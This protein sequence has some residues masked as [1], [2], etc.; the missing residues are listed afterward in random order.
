MQ[1]AL[2]PVG[3]FILVGTLAVAL[4]RRQRGTFAAASP[5]VLL[6]A[7]WLFYLEILGL[8]AFALPT[9]ATF[10]LTSEEILKAL[11][12]G[13]LAI[14][15]ILVGYEASRLVPSILPNPSK[16]RSIEDCDAK[17]LVGCQIIGWA[18][19]LYLLHQGK[20]GYLTY[21][22]ATTSGVGRTLLQL[23]AGLVPLSLAVLGAVIWSP[24]TFRSMSRR[25]AR[26]ILIG[27]LPALVL[28]SVASGVKGQLVTLVLPLAVVYILLRGKVPVLAIGC[29]AF[30]LITTFGGLQSYRTQIASGTLSPRGHG[31]AG[32]VYSALSDIVSNW[33][34]A[35]PATHAREFWQNATGEYATLAQTVA[36]IEARTPTSAPY[37]SP[38]RFLDG[39]FFFLPASTFQPPGFNLDTYVNT[40][41]RGGAGNSAAPATQPGDFY[42]SGGLPGVVIGELAVG[43]FVGILWR[44]LKPSPHRYWAVVLYAVIAT[45]FANAGIDF[46]SLMR[47][48]LDDLILYGIITRNAIFRVPLPHARTSDLTRSGLTQPSESTSR[49]LSHTT[50]TTRTGR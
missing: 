38:K 16:R 15:M 13:V 45:E 40:E 5:M 7:F 2:A 39:P 25:L 43:L 42:M 22:Q 44:F 29:I 14:I 37:V 8:G 21:G 12:L 41:Y 18:A 46:G 24:R 26:V 28:I 4:E 23:G 20:T 17:A 49:V 36:I 10:G 30:Y 33:G 47:Q 11:W 34:Q 35:S 48:S 9:T 27:N 1:R 32:P 50:L 6:S 19:T 31:I 3:I